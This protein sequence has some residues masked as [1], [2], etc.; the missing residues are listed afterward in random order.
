MARMFSSSKNTRRIYLDEGEY[1][2][3]KGDISVSVIEKLSRVAKESQ[4]SDSVE[5]LMIISQEVI[6]ELFISGKFK[7]DNGEFEDIQ[8]DQLKNMNFDALIAL[9][10]EFVKMPSL[11]K[12]KTAK[13]LEEEHNE[14]IENA[15]SEIS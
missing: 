7:N 1:I 13:K 3:I 14:K 11:E 9:M 4:G 6:S 10:G 2:D 15:I 8:A 5:S 12:A